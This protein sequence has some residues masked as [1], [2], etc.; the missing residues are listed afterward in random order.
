VPRRSCLSAKVLGEAVGSG[1]TTS[2]IKDVDTMSSAGSSAMDS[3]P[4]LA[5]A[6][7]TDPAAEA[8]EAAAAARRALGFAGRVMVGLRATGS[9]GTPMSGLSRYGGTSESV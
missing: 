7:A 5:G 3:E 4:V 8:A 9:R 6:G 2:D 1:A